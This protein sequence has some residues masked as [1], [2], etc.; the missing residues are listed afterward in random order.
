MAAF[1]TREALHYRRDLGLNQILFPSVGPLVRLLSVQKL[2]SYNENITQGLSLTGDLQVQGTELV[3]EFG[4]G[5][6][7][8]LIEVP[9]MPAAWGASEIARKDG[10]WQAT[11]FEA[12]LQ[13]QG[14]TKYYEFNFALNPA[15]NAYEFSAYREPQPPTMTQDFKVFK[16]SWDG[17]SKH[18]R[19]HLAN[20][21]GYHKFHV[22]LTAILQEK[23]GAKHYYALAHKGSKPDFHIIESFILQRGS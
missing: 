21:S 3:L 4:L 14:F 1:G 7:N 17:A 15:W 12:F 8:G 20:Q 18:L 19:V 23:S 5:D 11:C 6:Q 9:K 10:L 16:M 13:P 22:G 2:I